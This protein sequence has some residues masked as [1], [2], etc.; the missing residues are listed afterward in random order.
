MAVGPN[1][2][3]HIRDMVFD[4]DSAGLKAHAAWRREKRE[5]KWGS[6]THTPP[7]ASQPSKPRPLPRIDGKSAGAGERDDD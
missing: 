1:T 7:H 4:R 3:K 6:S 2:P 5:A